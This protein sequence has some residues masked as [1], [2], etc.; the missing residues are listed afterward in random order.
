MSEKILVLLPQEELNELRSVLVDVKSLLY[1][2][3][4]EASSAGNDEL[5]TSRQVAAHLAV[6]PR[7]LL[8]W[9]KAGILPFSQVGRRVLYR[10]RD[11]ELL[12]QRNHFRK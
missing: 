7:T 5:L 4:E 12:L 8:Q 3:R 2:I 9:R 10:M 1:K 11:I 6:T